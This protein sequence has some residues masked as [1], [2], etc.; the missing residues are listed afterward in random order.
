MQN[1]YGS[2]FS[3]PYMPSTSAP[4]PPPPPSTYQIPS[5]SFFQGAPVSALRQNEGWGVSAQPP[6]FL[7]PFPYSQW[8]A[9]PS[10]P[11]QQQPPWQADQPVPAGPH[12]VP[13][14]NPNTYGPS[15]GRQD[16][17]PERNSYGS[18]QSAPG[19]GFSQNI[20]TGQF[21][22][23]GGSSAARLNST[24]DPI[25]RPSSGSQ[26]QVNSW[27]SQQW[28]GPPV[29]LP[30]QLVQQHEQNPQLP[31]RPTSVSQPIG[32]FSQ[33]PS[34]P[35][36][37][38][39][40]PR[41]TSVSEL[42]NGN[43]QAPPLPPRPVL[44]PPH[45]SS[46][47][48]AQSIIQPAQS[49]PY[50]QQST[51]V[52]GFDQGPNPPTLPPLPQGYQEEVQHNPQAKL[53]HPPYSHQV[54]TH[55][56]DPPR[57]QTEDRIQHLPVNQETSFI[58]PGPVRGQQPKNTI[59]QEVEDNS[60]VQ[61]DQRFEELA[62][63]ANGTRSPDESLMERQNQQNMY[64][65]PNFT[66]R[67]DQHTDSSSGL[68]TLDAEEPNDEDGSERFGAYTSHVSNGN[69]EQTLQP[70][71]DGPASLSESMEQR[72]HDS[73]GPDRESSLPEVEKATLE[74]SVSPETE[75]GDEVRST[76]DELKP[77]VEDDNRTDREYDSLYDDDDVDEKG[78]VIRPKKR[79]T[80]AS[81]TV[82]GSPALPAH[83]SAPEKR[84]KQTND[85]SQ[86]DRKPLDSDHSPH[87]SININAQYQET[88]SK[89]SVSPSDDE[90]GRNQVMSVDNTAN[91]PEPSE[92]IDEVIEAWQKT[93]MSPKPEEVQE[94]IE[95]SGSAPVDEIKESPAPLAIAN[96]M[97]EP[98]DKS[99]E[100][101]A[102]SKASA[103]RLSGLAVQEPKNA[104]VALPTH[105]TASC[106]TDHGPIGEIASIYAGLKTCYQDSL[107]RYAE[108]LRRE[109]QAS[110][111]EER[112]QIFTDFM[113]S[114]SRLRGALYG[115]GI[116]PR[117]D[118]N[119]ISAGL[120][121]GKLHDESRRGDYSEDRIR[122]STPAN[123]AI[124]SP[125]LGR[126]PTSTP[127]LSHQSPP[128]LRTDLKDEL[129]H[130]SDKDIT[131]VQIL[132]ESTDDIEYS[133]GGRPKIQRPQRSDQ[134]GA[135]PSPDLRQLQTQQ[136]LRSV[137][138][139]E[140][141]S[142]S[143][144][145]SISIAAPTS[146]IQQKPAYSPRRYPEVNS[147]L[148]ETNSARSRS[149]TDLP[150]PVPPSGAY[151]AASSSPRPLARYDLAVELDSILPRNGLRVGEDNHSKAI[152]R[153]MDAI[154]DDFSILDRTLQDWEVR[155]KSYRGRIERERQARQ[156]E[157]RQ[158]I[159]RLYEE[160]Q[161]G[162]GDIAI[163]EDEFR[164]SEIRKEREEHRNEYQRFLRNVF[165][166]VTDKLHQEIEQLEDQ[167]VHGFDLLKVAIA[168][169]QGLEL[170][171][172]RPRY[173]WV[174][175]RL[176]GLY[177]KISRR[178]DIIVD[179]KVERDRR[180][181]LAEVAVLDPAED[182]AKLKRLKIELDESARKANLD[183]A[184][185][186]HHRAKKLIKR[187]EE[188]VMSGIE[189]NQDY[190]EGITQIILKIREAVPDPSHLGDLRTLRDALDWAERVLKALTT[191]SE[192][193]MESFHDAELR[194][195]TASHGVA[196]AEARMALAEPAV[197][198]ELD[199]ERLQKERRL[200][201]EFSRRVG[202][203][204]GDFE[205]ARGD[206]DA[207]LRSLDGMQTAPT[208]TSPLPPID[209]DAAHQERIRKALEAAKRRNADR[210]RSSFSG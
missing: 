180:Y 137:G 168:G 152:G 207:I 208:I 56:Y 183:A 172:D 55:H 2:G 155:E 156:E 202:L 64:P 87:E 73:N 26:Q 37:P 198:Q 205:R 96:A 72:R 78:Q 94:S 209:G 189:A 109:S 145:D 52:Y 104:A 32:S 59:T 76:L 146:N 48:V 91:E 69:P 5:T 147:S 121:E 57:Q 22:G 166:P 82:T 35:Q 17:A 115:A 140:P 16:Y 97:G 49:S 188:H 1:S 44:P 27:P 160:N 39:L 210:E 62:R 51:Q 120:R 83:S 86:G 151:S 99:D 184:K 36:T 163:L 197:F 30:T 14:Y 42:V 164:Q 74:A 100:T 141:P 107:S 31:P 38:P 179:A 182:R 149:P 95:E 150:E 33:A 122:Q 144:D 20:E 130:K 171:A 165:E 61:Q 116:G 194:L 28:P 77:T 106:Q 190:M 112:T 128:P 46:P 195:Q 6:A 143:R 54:R 43:L 125:R 204:R 9:A 192:A 75:N 47:P 187:L 139:V 21:E 200:K 24:I 113:M 66:D 123:N 118:A 131:D 12:G 10:N 34:Q 41:P 13:A 71:F 134:P 11:Q 98:D 15:L 119:R 111:D 185:S 176:V 206:I 173:S 169:K 84:L 89:A 136:P 124:N 90:E 8:P 177:D 80:G 193:L 50:V 58:N 25:A 127:P 101:K 148:P 135:L 60:H 186:Q 133:P 85:G 110:S 158:N 199:V 154:R 53:I 201:E 157:S 79:P 161:I 153:A 45:P 29:P 117:K 40:P 196:D 108:V 88:A 18:G 181:R 23:Y 142:R 67:S 7:P 68:H 102:P 65:L 167:Y 105:A 63:E 159:D 203:V 174:I 129:L 103:R 191:N 138:P 178:W 81:R 19:L 4:I 114:E 70:N 170:D 3:Q 132:V 126:Q 162:Y 92:N 93:A 175:R